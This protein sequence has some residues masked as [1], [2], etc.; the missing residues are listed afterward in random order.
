MT[1]EPDQERLLAGLTAMI[2]AVTGEDEQWAATVTPA[3]RLEGD[4]RLESVEVTALAER[5]REAYGER[6]D[7]MA[8]LAELDIDQLIALTVADVISYLAARLPVPAP[9]R[10]GG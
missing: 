6:A 8:F 7:L 5:I 2:V 3:S 4:L 1:A 9:A 10:D